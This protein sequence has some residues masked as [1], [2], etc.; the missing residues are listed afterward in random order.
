M[1]QRLCTTRSLLMF[2]MLTLFL[3]GHA[4]AV[5]ADPL[6]PVP[7][8][9]ITVVGVANQVAGVWQYRYTL[10]N[11]TNVNL[12]QVQFVVSEAITHRGIHHENPILLVNAF[13]FDMVLPAAFAG[14]ANHN[15][16]WSNL[17]LP[18]NGAVTL[19]FDDIHGPAMVT[20]AIQSQAIHVEKV[21]L[22]PAPS[23]VPEP[24]TLLLLG[25]GL[26][27]VA[28]KMRRQLKNR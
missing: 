21:N 2:V 17:L 9:G 26:A 14:I 7:G 4:T 11:T 1:K 10:T 16:S 28:A 13:R 12:N 24:A 15:Y 25:A 6:I 19:G 27:G 22:L 20:W 5:K 18:V 23:Q 8:Q 3:C